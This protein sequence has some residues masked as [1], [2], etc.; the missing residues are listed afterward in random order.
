[1]ARPSPARGT[2][3][4]AAVIF[5]IFRQLDCSDRRRD[6]G[7]GLGLH[8]VRRLTALLGGTI[9]VDSEVGTG[10]CFR[11]RLPLRAVVAHCGMPHRGEEALSA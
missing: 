5:E 7:V 10:S 1:M 2:P 9:A 3:R 6:D 11:I 4:R 8:I